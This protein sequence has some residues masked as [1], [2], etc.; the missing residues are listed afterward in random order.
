MWESGAYIILEGQSFIEDK[1]D[2][3]VGGIVRKSNN[4]HYKINAT[5]IINNFSKCKIFETYDTLEELIAKHFD[6]L[7]E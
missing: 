3:Y 7:L 4:P 6:K 1:D 2:K 5:M